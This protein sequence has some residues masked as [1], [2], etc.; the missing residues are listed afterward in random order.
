MVSAAAWPNTWVTVRMRGTQE[1]IKMRTSNMSF[2]IKHRAESA[3]P[4]QDSNDRHSESPAGL[5]FARQL[6]G[7]VC[8]DVCRRALRPRAFC[9]CSHRMSPQYLSHFVSLHPFS[10]M[11][12]F[13]QPSDAHDTG[14]LL[15]AFCEMLCCMLYNSPHHSPS[16]LLLIYFH[17]C[18]QSH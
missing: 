15:R 6:V 4:N 9:L 5:Y 2:N 11:F 8:V 10:T 7:G 17:L 1:V 14:K 18:I 16:S 13:L 12:C 3:S